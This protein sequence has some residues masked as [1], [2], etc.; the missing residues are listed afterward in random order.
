MNLTPVTS[1]TVRAVG[2]D[3]YTQVLRVSFKSG[4]TYEYYN[5]PG[6]LYELMMLPH[7]WRRVGRQVRAH[8]Y[9]RV[10]A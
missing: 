8:H 10:A 6:H 5:V 4:S 9:R 1:D 7:P 3:Y 2:Y